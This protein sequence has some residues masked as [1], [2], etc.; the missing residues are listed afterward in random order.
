MSLDE[1]LS[2]V[3]DDDGA[4]AAA[5]LER[6]DPAFAERTR[7]LF[8]RAL[9]PQWLSP[10]RHEAVVLALDALVTQLHPRRLENRLRRIEQLSESEVLSVLQLVSVVGLH[11]VSTG[12]P[13]LRDEVHR[14]FGVPELDERQRALKHRFENE[15]PRP[16]ALDPMYGSILELD[17]DYFEAFRGW[18]DHVWQ[19]STLDHG[20]L[21]LVCIAIDVA[22]THLYEPGITRHAREA[23]ACG[24]TPEEILEVV[25]LAS[26]EGLRTLVQGARVLGP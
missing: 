4:G 8:G 13:L 20:T 7:E 6:T 14:H 12:L 16:R 18:I 22:C 24:V 5:W 25:Q 11:S 21:H 23:F 26:V 2:L 3:A 10:Q 9:T 19:T 1:L 15:G 17:A